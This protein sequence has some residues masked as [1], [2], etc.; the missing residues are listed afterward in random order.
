MKHLKTTKKIPAGVVWLGLSR[1][2]PNNQN[3]RII[4]ALAKHQGHMN[5]SRCNSSST[6]VG[7]LPGALLYPVFCNMTSNS[8]KCSAGSLSKFGG[9]H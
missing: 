1:L 7:V 6:E 9:S 4:A 3:T 2:L 5:D 8:W